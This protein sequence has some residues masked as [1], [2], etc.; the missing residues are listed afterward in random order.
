MLSA[1]KQFAL[2]G[3]ELFIAQHA[4]GMQI[5]KLLQL[6]GQVILGGS[7]HL[8]RGWGILLRRRRILLCLLLGIRGALL[9]GLVVGGLLLGLLVGPLL[10]LVMVY[11]TGGTGDDC[12]AD[13]GAGN[14]SS[15]CSSSHHVDLFSLC[16]FR[17]GFFR[18]SRRHLLGFLGGD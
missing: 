17:L 15:Y 14:A 18:C 4:L 6:G 3:C 2:G 1:G 11:R 9:V 5:G 12:R 16:R 7:C 13:R 8:R 10:F